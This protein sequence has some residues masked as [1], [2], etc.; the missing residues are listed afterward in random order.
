MK[1]LFFWLPDSILNKVSF[2]S[3]AFTTFDQALPLKAPLSK[4]WVIYV[5]QYQEA[6]SRLSGPMLREKCTAVGNH[7]RPQLRNKEGWMR[8]LSGTSHSK[9]ISCWGHGCW[10]SSWILCATGCLLPTE[11]FIHVQKVVFA[12]TRMPPCSASKVIESYA[13]SK[14]ILAH[15]SSDHWAAAALAVELTSSP[16]VRGDF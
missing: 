12:I 5:P 11:E 4:R 7:C 2:F 16:H 13:L 15:E 1:A 14:T 6:I 9:S 3:F 10:K 8:E